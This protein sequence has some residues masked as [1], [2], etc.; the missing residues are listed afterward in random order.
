[1]QLFQ[2]WRPLKKNKGCAAKRQQDHEV[3]FRED[4]KNLFDVAHADALK[5]MKT[6]EDNVNQVGEA[7]WEH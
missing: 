3:V 4:M 7:L 6:Q 5:I 1:M 2:R